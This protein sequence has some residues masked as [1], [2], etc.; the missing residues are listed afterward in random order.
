MPVFARRSGPPGADQCSSVVRALLVLH[1][2][3][4]ITAKHFFVS[5]DAKKAMFNSLAHIGAIIQLQL[6]MVLHILLH[7]WYCGCQVQLRHS[8]FSTTCAV[9]GKIVRAGDC[10]MVRALTAQARGPGFDS[11]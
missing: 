6:G 2:L 7:R 11:Q 8:V 10:P 4:L 9:Y 5:N 3:H 1:F